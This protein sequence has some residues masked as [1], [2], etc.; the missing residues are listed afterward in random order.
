MTTTL[1]KLLERIRTGEA[2]PDEVAR[3]RD[4]VRGDARLPAEL[5]EVGLT[6][7]TD[8]AGDAVGLLAVLGRAP[9]FEE[10]MRDVLADAGGELLPDEADDGWEAIA[11][12]LRDGLTEAARDVEVADAVMMR[13]PPA[14]V[15]GPATAQAV[16]REAGSVDVAAD[17]MSALGEAEGLSGLVAEAVTAE[18]G[19]V[20]VADAVLA[21]VASAEDRVAVKE[22]VA[23]ESGRFELAASVA[24]DLGHGA[25]PPVADAVS[26]EAGRVEVVDAVIEAIG[27][28]ALPSLSEAIAHEA[29]EVEVAAAVS[30]ALPNGSL[31]P[32]AEAV[33][34]EAGSVDVVEAVAAELAEASTAPA[35]PSPTMPAAVQAA[36]VVPAAVNRRVVFGAVLMAALALLTFV[37]LGQLG[38]GEGEGAPASGDEIVFAAAGDVVVEDLDY[39]DDVVVMQAEGDEGAVILWMEGA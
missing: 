3:A 24:A 28:K 29:G 6:D 14:W 11:G 13:L 33:A 32:V 4:L 15:Y 7:T 31:P 30:D 2:S 9:L 36:P 38:S 19:R 23:S 8:L 34:A 16:E 37:G 27:G 39:A 21:A 35:T 17:A 1:E 18:A 20:E 22:A 5:R 10:A 25:L 26:A 12:A